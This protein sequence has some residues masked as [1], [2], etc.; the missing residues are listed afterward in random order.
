MWVLFGSISMFSNFYEVYLHNKMCVAIANLWWISCK[1]ETSPYLVMIICSVCVLV[2][3]FSSSLS[4]TWLIQ[5][6]E[7]VQPF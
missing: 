4:L 1:N 5:F 3:K 2:P 7:V 6:V